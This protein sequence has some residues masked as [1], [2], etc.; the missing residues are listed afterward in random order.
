[1][2]NSAN[3]EKMNDEDEALRG[4]L[5]AY[6]ATRNVPCA[7]CGHNLR[8]VTTGTCPECGR[9]IVVTVGHFDHST[10]PWIVAMAL[11]GLAIFATA[12]GAMTAIIPIALGRGFD[13]EAFLYLAATFAALATAVAGLVILTKKRLQIWNSGG[14]VQWAIAMSVVVVPLAAFVVVAIGELVLR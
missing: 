8:G 6:L 2:A 9:E 3:D 12:M 5:A 13:F 11:Y 4:L 14:F 10:T 1:M 7:K